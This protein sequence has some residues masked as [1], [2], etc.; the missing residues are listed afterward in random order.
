MLRGTF[1]SR[2]EEDGRWTEAV[3][4][5]SYAV[6]PLVLKTRSPA[7]C[8]IRIRDLNLLYVVPCIDSTYAMV[9][10]NIQ[11]IPEVGW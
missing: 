6:L 8:Y 2:Y 3:R 4:V 9:H 11:E 10:V 7:D 5:N 1:R